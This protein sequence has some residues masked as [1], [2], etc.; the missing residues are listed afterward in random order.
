MEKVKRKLLLLLLFITLAS[1]FSMGQAFHEVP[2]GYR[3]VYWVDSLGGSVYE[4]KI[5][6]VVVQNGADAHFSILWNI[7][8][9][10]ILSLHETSADGCPGEVRTCE[11]KVCKSTGTP[12]ITTINAFTPN[13]DNLNDVFKPILS[14]DE[15]PPLFKLQIFNI[16]GEL[17]FE[18]N[19][20]QSGW[21]GTFKSKPCPV[22]TYVFV[23]TYS[24]QGKENRTTGNVNLIR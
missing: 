4:W 1:S 21:N 12:F 7:P 10:Y 8:G 22:G 5:D 24:L 18:S 20:P 16:W 15:V 6:S 3:G 14:G 17:L 13:N 2:V 23:L 11:I 19:N 9:Q